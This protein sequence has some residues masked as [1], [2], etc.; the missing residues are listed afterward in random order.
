M[1]KSFQTYPTAKVGFYSDAYTFG[2]TDFSVDVGKMKAAG[3]DFITTCMDANAVLALAKE[4]RAQQ[5]DAIQ[6]LPNGYDQEFMN[7]NSGFF[8]GSIVRVPF[9]PFETKPRPA[10]LVEYLKW[11]EK[12]NDAPNEYS[13]YGWINGAMLYEG[14]LGAGPNFTQRK[15]IDALNRLTKDTGGGLLP[16][17]DW[18]TQHTETRSPLGCAA[19]VTVK[20]TKFVPAF[21]PA[22]KPFLCFKR[23]AGL[24][25]KPTFK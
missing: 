8:Q 16:G 4:A 24:D 25:A 3:V 14:L 23:N 19:Y 20:G 10:G 2:A 21:V 9:A 17:I 12:Q 13:T 7:A 5:L 6:Y 18:T 11:M 22:G 1:R 15:V